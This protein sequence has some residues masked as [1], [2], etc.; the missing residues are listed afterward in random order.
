MTRW[1]TFGTCRCWRLRCVVTAEAIEGTQR[2][3]LLTS[4]GKPVPEEPPATI[5]D[6][7]E[8]AGTIIAAPYKVMTPLRQL[9]AAKWKVEKPA[10]A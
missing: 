6:A 7:V 8:E 2:P 1:N 10:P 9:I 3:L 5:A 4:N